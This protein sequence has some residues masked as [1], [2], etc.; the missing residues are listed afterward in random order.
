MNTLTTSGYGIV[1]LF[2]LDFS[3]TIISLRSFPPA[4]P[5]DNFPCKRGKMCKL[6]SDNK[7]GCVCQEPAECPP[8]VN[9]YDH[10]G[11]QNAGDASAVTTGSCCAQLQH[12]YRFVGP[13][14]R[15]TTRPATSSPPNA[16]WRAPRKDTGCTWTTPARA[17]VSEPLGK[18]PWLGRSVFVAKR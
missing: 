17:N 18:K 10:V 5:C 11:P 12:H 4:D 9:E 16:S 13:T 6:D 14:T 8:S 1:L 15:R 7:P 3:K 2:P